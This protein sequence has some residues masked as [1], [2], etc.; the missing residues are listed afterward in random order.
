MTRSMPPCAREYAARTSLCAAAAAAERS[1]RRRFVRGGVTG[2]PTWLSM[3]TRWADISALP[4]RGWPICAPPN[5]VGPPNEWFRNPR[6]S[7]CPMPPSEPLAWLRYAGSDSERCRSW[8]PLAKVC[9]G[10]SGAHSGAPTPP[11]SS[12]NEL[13]AG[14]LARASK[15]SSTLGERPL[16]GPGRPSGSVA[17][18]A[19][20]ACGRRG[21]SR[22]LS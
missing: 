2:M 17:I 4:S 20:E 7:W 10:S 21:K 1:A 9:M 11:M 18:R 15:G 5:M 19:G 8:S 14:Q 13:S 6:D 22:R 12:T 16:E 3:L